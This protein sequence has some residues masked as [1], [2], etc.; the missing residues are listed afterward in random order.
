MNKLFFCFLLLISFGLSFYDY[1]IDLT[2][3]YEIKNITYNNLEYDYFVN[4][5]NTNNVLNL[6]PYNL[7]KLGYDYFVLLNI[8]G[9]LNITSTNTSIV[10]ITPKDVYLNTTNVHFNY[11]VNNYTG[12]CYAIID[13]EIKN[14]TNVVN[15][16]NVSFNL[17]LSSGIHNWYV[18]CGNKTT[19]ITNFYIVVPKIYILSPDKL[20]PEGDILFYVKV[21]SFGNTTS[22][23]EL[24]DS[25]GNLI[26]NV[27]FYN[28]LFDQKE[29]NS[30]KYVLKII[31]KNNYTTTIKILNFSVYKY[32]GTSETN[33]PEEQWYVLIVLIMMLIYITKNKNKI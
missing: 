1:Y 17:S 2:K 6:S 32:F 29:L 5:L 30:G 33:V 15:Y 3:V 13:G 31:S 22:K 12:K 10:I 28:T 24:Y 18:I 4:L 25:K 11:I 27:T 9:T 14:I 8:T 21:I 26:K 20:E 7:S 16:K 19:N 23:F